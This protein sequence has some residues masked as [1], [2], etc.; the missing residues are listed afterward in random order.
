MMKVKILKNIVGP[1][2]SYKKGKV[3]NVTNERAKHLLD[4]QFAEAVEEEVKIE[5]AVK[6]TKK[7]TRKKTV[8]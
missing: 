2:G 3:Y 7:T 6:A 5:K 1:L 8:K 4:C